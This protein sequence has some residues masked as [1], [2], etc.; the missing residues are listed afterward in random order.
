MGEGRQGSCGQREGINSSRRIGICSGIKLKRFFFSLFL[1]TSRRWAKMLCLVLTSARPNCSSTFKLKLLFFAG[2]GCLEKVSR[3]R[4]LVCIATC[5][6][7]YLL[8]GGFGSLI[9]GGICEL[10]V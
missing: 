2:G 4:P 3:R 9:G 1:G 7:Q 6:P 5:W 10:S 8:G